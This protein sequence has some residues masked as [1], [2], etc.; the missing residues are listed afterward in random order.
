M[1]KILSIDGGGIRGLIPAIIL[2]EIEKRTGKVCSELFDI[3]A[4]SSTG[5]IIALALNVPNDQEKAKYSANDIINLYLEHGKDIF[6]KPR[7]FFLKLLLP[8]YNSKNIEQILNIYFKDISILASIKPLL[9]PSY[10]MTTSTPFFF[11][12]SKAELFKEDPNLTLEMKN[13]A[14]ATT[15]AP[16]YFSPKKFRIFSNKEQLKFIDGGVFANNPTMCA[17]SEVLKSEKEENIFVLS[18]GTGYY[19]NPTKMKTCGL[20][21]WATEILNTTLDGVNDTV[22]YQARKILSANSYFRL[23]P[24]L[25]KS[26]SKMDNVSNKNLTELYKITKEYIKN[27]SEKINEIC[28]FLTKDS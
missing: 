8:K 2:A 16:T 28:N 3:F 26:T 5:A 17:I 4:G 22:D 23:Q 25:T 11:K 15:A 19:D 18:L 12:T 21:G 7:P 10:E 14:R 27:N 1:K 9:I 20:I 6:K 13:I 24:Y